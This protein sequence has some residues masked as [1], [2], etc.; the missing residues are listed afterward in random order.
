MRH[1]RQQLVAFGHQL[2]MA[3]VVAV[4]QVELDTAVTQLADGGRI[5]CQR[6]AVF[7]GAAG[8]QLAHQHLGDDTGGVDESGAL[9]PV[10]ERYEADGH[11]LAAA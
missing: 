3:A 9:V 8:H 5:D 10:F 11:V 2:G 6:E 7:D 4:L 1:F